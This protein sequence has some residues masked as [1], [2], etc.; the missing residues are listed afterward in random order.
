MATGNRFNGIDR[1]EIA[2]QGW[3]L[4]KKVP[5]SLIFSMIVQACLVV[6]A[7]ADI[8]KDVEVLKVQ[9][10][11][12]FLGQHDR[13]R[14]Q[15]DQAAAALAIIRAQLERMENKMDRVIEGRSK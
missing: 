13:D 4:D 5:L 6:W 12:E 1:R 9:T 14:R 11:S 7:I 2:Q 15:D 3:H 8:K 10:A